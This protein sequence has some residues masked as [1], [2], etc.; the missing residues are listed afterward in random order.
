M[1]PVYNQSSVPALTLEVQAL[2]PDGWS[3]IKLES[4]LCQCRR[5]GVV[6]VCQMEWPRWTMA[7]IPERS[8]AARDRLYYYTAMKVLPTSTLD[9]IF[10]RDTCLVWRQDKKIHGSNKQERLP[11]ARRNGL[12][13]CVTCKLL[14]SLV[15]L[16]DY[17]YSSLSI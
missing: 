9:P 7:G 5:L 2:S 12:V 17:H 13:T 4:H 10:W 3:T 6:F 15:Y 8:G 11:V 1:H 14:P 16:L